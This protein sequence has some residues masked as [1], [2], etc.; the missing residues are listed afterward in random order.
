MFEF[1]H[2][3]LCRL[4]QKKFTRRLKE[5]TNIKIESRIKEGKRLRLF[6]FTLVGDA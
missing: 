4:G 5:D 3:L 2:V 1:N 6:P